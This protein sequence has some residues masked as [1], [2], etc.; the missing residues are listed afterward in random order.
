MWRKRVD[1]SPG[2][3]RGRLLRA[4]PGRGVSVG[5]NGAFLD[6]VSNGGRVSEEEED[7]G[8]W[9]LPDRRWRVF[10]SSCPVNESSTMLGDSHSNSAISAYCNNKPIN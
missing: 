4:F 9:G 10:S 3:T 6:D 2:G 1:Q 5:R 7:S 8:V